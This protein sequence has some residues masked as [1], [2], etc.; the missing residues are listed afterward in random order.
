MTHDDILFLGADWTN[1]EEPHF[2]LS[3]AVPGAP[4]RLVPITKALCY[5]AEIDSEHYCCGWFDVRS[6]VPQHE[7]C[8]TAEVLVTGTQCRRCQYR[9]GFT[10]VHQSHQAGARVPE[11]IARYLAQPHWLYVDVFASGQSKIGTVAQSRLGSRLSEQGPVAAFY[12]AEAPNGRVVRALEQSVSEHFGLRQ[13]VSGK[14]KLQA[15][16]SRVEV[17]ELTEQAK[18]LAV[19]VRSYLGTHPL[20]AELGLPDDPRPWSLP[21]ASQAVFSRTPVQLDGVSRGEGEHSLH[22]QGMTG[23]IALVS[24]S[25]DTDATHLTATNLGVLKGRRLRLGDYASL[26]VPVQPSML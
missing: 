22:L 5:S 24:P 15:L 1:P 9:E 14:R 23:S 2:R 8:E 12:V 21:K 16:A 19:Q 20:A 10:T 25:A 17:A 3:D 6:E 13:A 7:S 11:H 26:A 4:S 18:Q